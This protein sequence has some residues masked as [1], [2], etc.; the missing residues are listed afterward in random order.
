MA[1]AK[2]R[3]GP[4]KDEKKDIENEDVVGKYWTGVLTTKHGFADAIPGPYNRVAEP[5]EYIKQ[6]LQ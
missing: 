6:L 2:V 3:A 5:P 4:P 1:S